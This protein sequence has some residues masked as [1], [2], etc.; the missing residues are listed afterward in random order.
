LGHTYARNATIGNSPL[1]ICPKGG[2]E[3]LVHGMESPT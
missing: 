3:A 1:P 2:E